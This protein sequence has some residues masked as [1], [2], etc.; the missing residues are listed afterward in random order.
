MLRCLN[1]LEAGL[2]ALVY[3]SETAGLT[4]LRAVLGTFSYILDSLLSFFIQISD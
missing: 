3:M 1:A 2:E 4:C